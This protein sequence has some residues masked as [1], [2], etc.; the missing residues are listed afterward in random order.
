[1]GCGKSKETNVEGDDEEEANNPANIH[2]DPDGNLRHGGNIHDRDDEMHKILSAD[3]ATEEHGK[4]WYV[5]DDAWMT[6]WL[7]FVSMGKGISPA[8]GPIQNRNLLAPNY[9]KNRFEARPG[10]IMSKKDVKGHYKRVSKEQW[11]FFIDFYP[12]S[13]PEIKMYFKEVRVYSFS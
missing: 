7:E 5:I 3:D 11:D 2:F 12:D 10:L 4:L 9:E 6:A 13:G 8:P 1:M